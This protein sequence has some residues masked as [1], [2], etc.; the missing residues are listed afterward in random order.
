MVAKIDNKMFPSIMK[1]ATHPLIAG[2]NRSHKNV[3]N[4]CLEL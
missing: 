3:N 2:K 4:K 1:A